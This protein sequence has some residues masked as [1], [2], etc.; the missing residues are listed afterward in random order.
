MSQISATEAGAA[1]SQM[2]VPERCYAPGHWPVWLL[3]GWFRLAA[4]LPWR[5]AIRLHKLIGLICWGLCVGR[6][7][8]VRQSIEQC[9]PELDRRERNALVRRHFASLGACLAETAFAWCGKVDTSLADFELE[10]AD[11]IREA[12]AAGRGV[13]LYTGHFTPIEICAPI[14]KAEFPLVGFMYNRLRNTLLNDLQQRGRRHAGDLSIPSDDVRAMVRALKQNA[15][16]WYA[17]D[18]SF[19]RQA[20]ITLPFFGHPT[21]VSSATYRLARA[22]GAAVIPFTYYRKSDDSGYVMRFGPPVANDTADNEQYTRQLL[23]SLERMIRACPEQ[24]AWTPNRLKYGSAAAPDDQA[25]QAAPDAERHAGATGAVSAVAAAPARRASVR[26]LL[27]SA[28]GVALFITAADNG[29]FY[30]ALFEA[31]DGSDQQLAIVATMSVMVLTTLIITLSLAVGVRL[32]KLIAALLLIVGA[33]TGYFMSNYGIVVD[34][35]M[36]RNVAETDVREASPL[37]TLPA[38]LH[39]GLYGVVPAL[40][41]ILMPLARIGWWRDL[42]LRFAMVAG[43]VLVFV[44]TVYFNYGPV[45]FFGHENHALRMQINPVYPLY[46]LVRYASRT[47]DRPP[48]ERQLIAA[49]RSAIAWDDKPLLLV[50]VMGETARADRFALNGYRRDTN[51]FTAGTDLVNFPHVQSCGTSTA[52][53]LPCIFSKFDR[54]TFSHAAFAENETLYQLLGRLGVST[55]WRDNSTGCKDI[56]TE[57]TFEHLAGE[58]DAAFCHDNVCVDEILLK[59]LDELIA[60]APRDRFVV[61]H[62]RG[63]HGPAYFSDTPEW[64]KE[65]LPECDLA[66]LRACDSASINNAYD[67]TIRY[68]DYILA[69]L[70]EL[71]GQQTD[72]YRTAMLYVSD[73]GESLGEKGL[74]LHGLPYSIAPAEQTDVPMVFWGSPE[75]F[76]AS[77]IDRNCLS[78]AAG[79]PLTHDAIFHTILPLF[80]I[81][82]PEYQSNLDMFGACRTA[83]FSSR[84]RSVGRYFVGEG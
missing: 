37:L 21:N 81:N 29:S 59:G 73:H 47:N 7:R 82:A 22:T 23:G 34:V 42:T 35:S 1:N 15:I 51:P 78:D 31:V 10:G 76:E 75:F 28:L 53:S 49:E 24:Y 65:Y 8:V 74:Y 45:T 25:A 72:R 57:E 80:D 38:L 33:A 84:G 4:Q 52:D 70:I 40:V 79:M 5:Q 62:Q 30:R 43:S 63:S 13:I 18:Q 44:A 55:S 11:Y 12:L 58:D 77:S 66:S 14:L 71:L 19:S 6:R 26:P 60:D 50:F 68:T 20:S 41:V 61:L 48:P 27:F 67:N 56:C 32:F 9:F 83:R 16:V 36:I 69:Q 54:G 64:A 17:P 2:S 3:I 46:S 39:I